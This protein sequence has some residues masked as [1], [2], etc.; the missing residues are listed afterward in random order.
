MQRKQ[1]SFALC[2][3]LLATT[4][5]VACYDDDDYVDTADVD[6]AYEYYYP[7]TYYYPADVMYSS[8]YY[9]DTWY[10]SDWYYA[11]AQ[12]RTAPSGDRRHDPG[13]GPGRG[14]LPWSGHGNAADG[15]AGLRR[16]R[17]GRSAAA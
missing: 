9:T 2:A 11:F 17:R 3:L 15:G 16:G 8:Y 5:A 12:T 4:G 7:S 13:A 6:Y 10:Y 14:G 1:A